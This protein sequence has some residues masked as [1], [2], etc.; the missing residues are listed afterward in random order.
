[1]NFDDK[2]NKNGSIDYSEVEE[3]IKQHLMEEEKKHKPK[4][5]KKMEKKT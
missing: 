2:E 4:I 5:N 3:I 1:L